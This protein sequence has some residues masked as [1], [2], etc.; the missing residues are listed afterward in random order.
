MNPSCLRGKG[1]G[2]VV[3]GVGEGGE[4]AGDME[5]EMEM[6]MEWE[7]RGGIRW[8]VSHG[9]RVARDGIFSYT[10]CFILDLFFKVSPGRLSY[11]LMFKLA[12][13]WTVPAISV[14]LR[15]PA[16]GAAYRQV[17]ILVGKWGGCVETTFFF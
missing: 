11:C 13:C 2:K 14:W 7:A 16:F 6:E 9:R 3:L 1:K 10:T 12:P 8:I 5:M 4:E 17:G 15:L